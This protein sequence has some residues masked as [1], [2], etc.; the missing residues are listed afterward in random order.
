M[1]TIRTNSLLNAVAVVCFLSSGCAGNTGEPSDGGP[2]DAAPPADAG[3]G[4][5]ASSPPTLPPLAASRTVVDDA[6][7]TAP[8]CADCHANAQGSDAMR[9]EASRPIAPFDLWRSSMM[10]SAARDPLWRAMMSAEIAATPSRKSEIEAKCFSCHG[11]MA[12]RAGLEDGVL[13][14]LEMVYTDTDRSQI[15]L[16]GVSC[17]VCHQITSDDFGEDSSYSGNFVLNDSQSIYGPHV[18]PFGMPMWRSTGYQPVYAEHTTESAL[19]G[20]CHTLFTNTLDPDGTATGD[21]FAEQTPYLEWRNSVYND[22]LAS[23]LLGAA[24]CQDCHV[25]TTSI[26]GVDIRTEI[27]QLGGMQGG[28]GGGHLS[29]RSPYGR[30]V[31]VGAN[32]FVPALIRDNAE[33]LQPNASAAALNATIA[34]ARDQLE[35]RSATLELVGATRDGDELRVTLLLRNL[36]GHKLP[37]GFPSRRSWVRLQVIDDDGQLV[38]SSGVTDDKG[39]IVDM[40]GQVL[41]SETRGGPIQPHRDVITQDDEVL[42]LEDIM[43]D[44]DGSPTFTLLRAA[45]HLKDNR[46]LP[47]GWNPNHPDAEHTGVHGAASQDESFMDGEDTVSY[48]FVAPTIDGPYRIQADFLYQTLSPR[49]AAELFSHSTSEIEAF[50]RYYKASGSPSETMAAVDSIVD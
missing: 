10:A 5:D 40:E 37:T 50:K 2:M 49:F 33:E 12:K 20:T 3:T 43:G 44:V 21:R 4:T 25:P 30:H 28:M 32:T 11:P 35:Q 6:F 34:A 29:A 1:C 26:D 18:D 13:P 48:E 22:E 24:G 41:A 15:L 7:A 23:P 31:F 19:C 38:F 46:L 42:I 27:A 16:D 17:T 36:A 47:K 39:R 9:D 8:L 45:E 14:T